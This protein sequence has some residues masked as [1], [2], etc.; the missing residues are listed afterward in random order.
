[1][2]TK[3]CFADVRMLQLM[4]YCVP[5]T[6]HRGFAAGPHWP[7]PGPSTLDPQ[8]TLITFSTGEHP[9][10]LLLLRAWTMATN[11]APGSRPTSFTNLSHHRLRSG[12]RTDSSDFISG[13]FLLS[14]S[15]VMVA[16]WN[17]ADHNIF[18]LWF[19]LSSFFLLFSSPNL[20]RRRLDVCHTST[21]GV[22]IV[23][24]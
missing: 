7:S 1:M 8:Q 22:A 12:R 3:Q 11:N 10:R 19:V 18:M 2:W 20:S 16:L 6:S 24:I 14:I 17:R 5:H 4:G 23:R 9:L 15:V 13:P 21:H